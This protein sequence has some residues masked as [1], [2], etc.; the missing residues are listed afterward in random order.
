M[1]PKFL[2]PSPGLIKLKIPY[3]LLC[4]DEPK[5]PCEDI[6]QGRVFRDEQGDEPP[7]DT[8]D[9][10]PPPDQAPTPRTCSR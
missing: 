6:L 5:D 2:Q 4:R 8:D 7:G 10:P 1:V 3:W 9:E